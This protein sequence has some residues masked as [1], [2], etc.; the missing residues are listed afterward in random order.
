M[1]H[2]CAR[3]KSA[4]SQSS[5]PTDKTSSLRP[6]EVGRLCTTRGNV[7][8]IAICVV[9]LI[10]IVHIIHQSVIAIRRGFVDACNLLTPHNIS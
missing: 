1:G 6:R 5:T 10:S 9:T 8:A 3:V 7:F 4:A 2:P